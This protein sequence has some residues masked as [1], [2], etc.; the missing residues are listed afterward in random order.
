[1]QYA[2]KVLKG[3]NNNKDGQSPSEAKQ[4]ADKVLKGRNL[5]K[6]GRSPSEISST[7]I[8]S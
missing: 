6:N 4:Y 3:R 8:K 7:L 1:M 5:N 2:D